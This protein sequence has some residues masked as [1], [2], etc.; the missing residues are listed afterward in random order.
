[1]HICQL[2]RVENSIRLNQETSGL[3]N[4]DQESGELHFQKIVVHIQ[5]KENSGMYKLKASSI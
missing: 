5:L 1:M 4:Y 2:L 3:E